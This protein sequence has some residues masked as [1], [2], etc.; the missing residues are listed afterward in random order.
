MENVRND[1]LNNTIYLFV[2]MQLE[3]FSSSELRPNRDYKYDNSCSEIITA[4]SLHC[5]T[6]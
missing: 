2:N 1:F 5:A 4:V 3:W 6:R